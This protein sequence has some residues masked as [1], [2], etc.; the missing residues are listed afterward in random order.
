MARILIPL[1]AEGFDPSESGIPWR[2]LHEAGHAVVFATPEGAEGRADPRMLTG[3]DL[4]PWRYVLRADA[5]G[6]AAYHAMAMTAEFRHPLP[7]HEL[8]AAAFDALLLPGGH[9]KAMRPYLESTRLQRLTAAMFAAGKP[10]GAICHGVVL[11]A[12]SRRAD[13]RS[14]LHGRRTTALLARQE[15]LAWRLTRLWLGEYYRTYK[16]TVQAE[17]T[18]ALARPEDFVEGPSRLRRDT[19]QRPDGFALMDGNYLSARWPGDAHRFAQAFLSL[20]S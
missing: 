14:V 18:A 4:G 9:A 3:Q 2:V 7:Y 11:A 8:D 15:L 13:G 12:R 19:P 20:L 10:V 5:N 16:Q 17:V 1:P 6:R